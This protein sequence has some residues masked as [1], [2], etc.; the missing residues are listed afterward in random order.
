MIRT[1]RNP[2][3]IITA[4]TFL[5]VVGEAA[6]NEP[7]LATELFRLCRSHKF[8]RIPNLAWSALT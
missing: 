8:F 5:G 1:P 4:P 2:I 3:L 6:Q 7:A